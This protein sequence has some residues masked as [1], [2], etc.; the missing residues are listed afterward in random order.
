MRP[1]IALKAFLAVS[2]WGASF[3]AT[4]VV[5]RE[6]APVTIIVVRFALGLMV[7]VSIVILRREWSPNAGW[8]AISGWRPSKNRD[9]G[10]FLFL[11][12]N[13]IFVHQ[14]LQ[15][16]GLK[17]T[18]ATNTGWMVALTPI[19]TA[20]LAWLL[21][22]E[23]FRLA[24]L[25]GLALAMLGTLLVVSRGELQSGTIG[26]PA[27]RGDL[28]VF[29]GAINW[30]V[31]S[32][33]SKRILT[34]YAP[35]FMMTVTMGLGWLMLLPLFASSAEWS[36]MQGLSWE[37]CTALLFLGLLCSGV[38]YVFWYDALGAAGAGQ[39][40]SF[41][42][43]EPLVTLVVAV[44]FLNEQPAIGTLVGGGLILAGVWSVNRYRD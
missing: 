43:L 13:G 30:A 4:K 22:K 7:L 17:S 18:S 40:A 16:N 37:S 21:M 15:V 2:F 24:Q 1:L 42:Y 38:A 12:F 26:L 5:L 23:A 3:V 34:R 25:L 29:L 6:L 28:L 11:G 9:W 44:L 33:L 8:S 31:F 20:V 10:W 35:S 36:E 41:L 14:L 19:F 32:V 27:T 39:V